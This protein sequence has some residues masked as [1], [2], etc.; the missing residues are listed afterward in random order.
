MSDRDPDIA[1]RRVQYDTPGLDADDLDAEP[2]EQLRRWYEAA[3]QAGLPEPNAM[4]VSTVDAD[5]P[6]ARVVLAR[7]IDADGVVFYTNH[8]SAKGRQ[9][10]P[11]PS[12]AATFV[13]LEMHRQVRVRG[14]AERV[15]DATRDA[16]FASRPRDSQIG[17]WASPQS[18]T[19]SRR[20][21]LDAL[22]AEATARFEG[23]EVPRPPHWGGWRIRPR[24]VEFWQGRPNRLH[25]RLVYVPDCDR[26]RVIRLAP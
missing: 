10:A 20:E 4:V 26:W 22:V 23:R 14:V 7:A 12:G 19:I 8:H 25:D 9:L 5:G 3:E 21:E 1:A 2:M 16:Y 6:D 18:E 11:S 24:S 13:W 15:D 17:A